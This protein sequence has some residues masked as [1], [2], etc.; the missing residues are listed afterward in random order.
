MS[1]DWDSI[2]Y[3]TT[4]VFK[5]EITTAKV[6]K[7]YDGDTITIATPLPY[8]NSPVFRFSV[9]LRGID[10]PEIRT[11]DDN[12]K[13]CGKKARGIMIE[14]VFGKIVRLENVDYDKYGRVLADVFIG[15]TN[16]TEVLL[17]Q[18]LAVAYQG[19]KKISPENW[20]EYHNTA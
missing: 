7:V 13:E 8:E 9:R 4:S 19:G 3:K 16:I 18:K 11:K 17:N 10:C 20:L 6:V 2:T 12:E 5:P 14:Q 1:V 15:D